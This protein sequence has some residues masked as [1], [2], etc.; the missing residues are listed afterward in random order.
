[1]AGVTGWNFSIPALPPDLPVGGGVQDRR[2]F[3]LL[4]PGLSITAHHALKLR[5]YRKGL[6]NFR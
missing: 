5:R 2:R 4:V 3:A 6:T 1:M